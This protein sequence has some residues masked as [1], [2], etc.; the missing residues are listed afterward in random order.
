[1]IASVT[2]T[3]TSTSP[4]RERTRA[5]APSARPSR[6]ASS[7]WT[8]IVQR[9][10]PLTSTFRLCIQELFERSS[11]RPIRTI[12]PLRGTSRSRSRVDVG[13]DLGRRELDPARRRPQDLGDARLE[14]PEIDPVRALLELARA[15]APPF[16]LRSPRRR[17]RS[18]AAGRAGARGRRAARARPAPPRD[19]VR[20]ARRHPWPPRRPPRR[21]RSASSASRSASAPWPPKIPASRS[22]ICQSRGRVGGRLEERR[23]EVGDVPDRRAGRA[24]CR[25][26]SARAASCP[27]GSRRR[28]GWSRSGRCRSRP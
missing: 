22:M 27:A 15:T 21:P 24:R 2:S 25:S 10:L 19:R 12:E 14:R 23:R 3:G 13:D 18:A 26:G 8:C 20:R 17:G 1:M 28:G 4:T 11:R 9:S 5:R 7:G 6:A 16:S